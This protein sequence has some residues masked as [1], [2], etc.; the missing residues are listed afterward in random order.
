M[1]V[2][3]VARATDARR[4]FEFGSGFGYSAYWFL[5]GMPDG[6]EIV[7]TEFD[8]DEIEMA[9]EFF[10]EAGVADRAHFEHGGVMDAVTRYDG[11]FDVVLIDHQR[12]MHPEAFEA[13][14]GKFPTGGVVA[15]NVMQTPVVQYVGERPRSQHARVRA[16]YALYP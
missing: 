1:S 8:A 3:S 4:V 11:P 13:V 12:G 10:G 6:G 5:R 7:L 2:R 15:D 16:R 14:R 9:E